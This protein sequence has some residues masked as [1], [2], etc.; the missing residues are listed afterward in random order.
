MMVFRAVAKYQLDY[1]QCKTIRKGLSPNELT[2]LILELL[3]GLLQPYWP[4]NE[5]SFE[6]DCFDE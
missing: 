6:A 4:L 5:L 2:R 1:Y 3:V